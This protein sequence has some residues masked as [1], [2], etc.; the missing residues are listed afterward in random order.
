MATGIVSIALALD[1][2]TV[3]S[4][5]LLVVTAIAWVALALLFASQAARDREWLADASSSPASLTAVAATAVLAS[6]L[7]ERGLHAVA[8]VLL[9]VAA[10]ICAG[11]GVALMRERALARSGSSFML[12]VSL[13]SL[14]G[15]AA[16]VASA[17]RAT[18]LLYPSMALCALGL[19]LYLAVLM[20]F[21]PREVGTGDGDHWIA[22]GA[23]AISA[24]TLIEIS[25][26]A[27]RQI[28]LH[29]LGSPLADLGAAV[30]IIALLWLP[31]LL[32]AE[33]AAPRLGRQPKRWSTLFPVGMY[34]ASGF[35]VARA[36]GL[37]FAASFASGWTWV[38]LALWAILAAAT[39]RLAIRWPTAQS[40]S[41]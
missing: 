1:D 37:S 8:A 4:R 17:Q 32:V 13:Q 29:S 3:L 9:V 6:G 5:V 15:L 24:L 12:T 28:T 7:D 10:A 35:E 2:Q 14:A 30:W 40:L 11:L 36:A 23:L 16:L 39:A 25:R 38:A 19:A 33:L 41:R 27:S 31:M 22:G 20:R 18:W 21:D 26:A 34:A